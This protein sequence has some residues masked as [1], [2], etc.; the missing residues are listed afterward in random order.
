MELILALLNQTG[1][2][3]LLIAIGYILVRLKIIPDSAAT[4][5]SK[6][7]TF[8]FVPALLIGTF[9]SN[10]TVD[11]LSTAKT[12]LIA[13]VIFELIVILLSYLI[14]YRTIK[15]AHLRNISIYGLCYA[16]FGYMGNAL[17][18][19][20]FPDIFLEYVIFTTPINI[21]IFIW[22]CPSLL[23]GDGK[24]ISLKKRIYNFTNPMFIAMVIGIVLGLLQA[25]VP[26]FMGNLIKSLGDCMT[27]IAMLLTGMIIAKSKLSEILRNKTIYLITFIRLIVYPLVFVGITYIFDIPESVEICALCAIAMPLGLN[28]VVIPGAYGKDTSVASGMSLVSH[29]L[30][31]I[32]IPLI[33]MLYTLGQ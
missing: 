24:K 13:S 9:I 29:V 12:L 14:L 2:L 4:I 28:S 15:D 17:V 16:N 19:A 31:C 20:I 32:T 23:I 10:F 33:F 18:S 25:P 26:K 1:F 7:E 3:V 8:L 5:L 27:P 22:A 6:L 30:S 21:S 11:K